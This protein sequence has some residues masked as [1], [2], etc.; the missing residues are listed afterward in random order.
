MQP[1]AREEVCDAIDNDCDGTV[2]EGCTCDQTCQGLGSLRGYCGSL[3][4]IGRPECNVGE[5]AVGEVP[6]CDDPW[7]TCCCTDEPE[8]V[9][10]VLDRN[11]E[12]DRDTTLCG[13]AL[14]DDEGA[15]GV[16]RIVADG[17]TLDCAGARVRTARRLNGTGI[18]VAA[19]VRDVTIRGCWVES[20]A[21][22]LGVEGGASN[23]Q[24][25][26]TR[27][28]RNQVGVSGV[29]FDGLLLRR[30]DVTESSQFGIRFTGGWADARLEAGRVVANNFTGIRAENVAS[31]LVV[32]EMI[33][34]GNNPAG[35]GQWYGGFAAILG[36]RDI[37]L[38]ANHI[39]GNR[40]ADIEG[41]GLIPRTWAGRDNTCGVVNRSPERGRA[42]TPG[43]TDRARRG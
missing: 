5:E 29:G 40:P 2:D 34:A 7:H 43:S 31:G 18:V 41:G 10:T 24:V 12:I 23:V 21:V 9:C 11:L 14:V 37:D 38:E 33:I 35:R 16:I 36:V 39:C 17:V 26:E 25:F 6:P 20:F 22:G 3:L 1:E 8:R 19:G 32:R 13:G 15:A 28:H 42:A 27:L 4:P 30:V